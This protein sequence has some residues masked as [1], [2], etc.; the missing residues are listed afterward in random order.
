MLQ[1]KLT[2]LMIKIN[3]ILIITY[4]KNL[5]NI[6]NQTNGILDGGSEKSTIGD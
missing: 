1:I 4:I 5:F 6:F 2:Y 3:K